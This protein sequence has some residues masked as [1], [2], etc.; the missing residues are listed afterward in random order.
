MFYLSAYS[1]NRYIVYRSAV[2]KNNRLGTVDI[3]FINKVQFLIFSFS[4]S[5]NLVKCLDSMFPCYSLLNMVVI[6][7]YMVFLPLPLQ[8]GDLIWNFAKILNN[9]YYYITTFHYFIS[10]ETANIQKKSE[11]FLLRISSANVNA[12]VVTCRY[13][14]I[15]NFSFRK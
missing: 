15:Y 1:E 3:I 8:W 12:S 5:R 11:V 10:V 9:S 4:D 7:L 13:P 6:W 14:Q 2:L